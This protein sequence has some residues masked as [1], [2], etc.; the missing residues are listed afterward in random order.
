MKTA[1]STGLLLLALTLPRLAAAQTYDTNTITVQTFAGSG[2]YGYWDGQGIFTMFN[3]P[4]AVV[5]DS[6]SN[7]F[8]LDGGNSLVRKIAPDA[9][10]TTFFNLAPYFGSYYSV[11]PMILDHSNAFWVSGSAT[12]LLRIPT[13]GYPSQVLLPN[14]SSAP[15]GLAVDSANSLYL[16]DTYANRIYRLNANSTWEIFAG[17]G[18]PGAVDGNWIFTSFNNPQALAFDAA[19]NLYVWDSGNHLIRRINQRRDVT[20]VAGQNTGYYYAPDADGTGTNASFGTIGAMAIDAAGSLL[21][22][23]GT[24][25]RRM[26]PAG[27]VTTLAGAFDQAAYTNGPGPLARFRNLAGICVAGGKVFVADRDDHRIRSLSFNAT[28]EPVPGAHLALK[29]LAGLEISGIAGRAYRIESSPDFSAWSEEATIVLPSN[30]YQWIDY[31]ALGS[32]KF[33]RAWLLP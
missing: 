3:G 20:T 23:C 19:D 5:A 32:R 17:S 24:S 15:R 2:F 16:A 22:A 18:N 14:G 4:S 9:T 8:V 21:L 31:A 25:I 30:S 11:G 10:V 12:Y 6:S 27:A 1:L 33:Y 26:T 7:L 29:T 13:S 28:P